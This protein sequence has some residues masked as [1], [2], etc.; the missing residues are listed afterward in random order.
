MNQ[1]AKRL[2]AGVTALFLPASPVFSQELS[3]IN[4]CPKVY[5]FVGEADP[6]VGIGRRYYIAPDRSSLVACFKGSR[7]ARGIVP[8]SEYLASPYLTRQDKSLLLKVSRTLQYSSPYV[9][10]IGL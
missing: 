8:M 9:L 5:E 7:M 2:I 6:S 10:N 3:P 4:D 1:V